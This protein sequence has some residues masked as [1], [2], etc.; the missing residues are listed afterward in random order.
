MPFE[1]FVKIAKRFLV[2]GVATSPPT[3]P[4][5]PQSELEAFEA[6]LGRFKRASMCPE[7]QALMDVLLQASLDVKKL[8]QAESEELAEEQNLKRQDQ[9]IRA[10]RIKALELE[11]QVA[12]KRRDE[13][14]QALLKHLAQHGCSEYEVKIP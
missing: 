5:A 4:K 6:L 1:L 7:G 9:H 2:P 3:R 10:Q 13:V 11:I 12:Y 8:Q 14:K